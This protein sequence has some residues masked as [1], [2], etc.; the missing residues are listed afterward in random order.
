AGTIRLG[1]ATHPLLDKHLPTVNPADPYALSAEEQACLSRLKQS[2]L[3]SPTL[4]Q[5]MRFVQK[6]GAMYLQRN[7]ALI[8]HGCLAVDAEGRFLPL[9]VDGK[10]LCGRALFKGLEQLVHRAFAR[11]APEDLDMLWY[12]WAG[13]L[14]PLFGKDRMATF[15]TY[16]L[17]DKETHKET[18]NP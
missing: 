9:I 7:D 15:E 17:K 13:P 18:K 8:F 5:Q 4:W 12:L 16:F 3:Y 10:A 1:D 2:F 11:R 14:S 6:R